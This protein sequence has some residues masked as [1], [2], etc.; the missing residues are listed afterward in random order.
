LKLDE[1][2]LG[3]DFLSIYVKELSKYWFI[4]KIC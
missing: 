2:Q 4:C 3:F 1:S